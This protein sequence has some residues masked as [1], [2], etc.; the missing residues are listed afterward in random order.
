MDKHSINDLPQFS[1]K[2]L[3]FVMSASG[4]G[5]AKTHWEKCKKLLGIKFNRLYEC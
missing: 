1:R 5:K 3:V 2:F 4:K